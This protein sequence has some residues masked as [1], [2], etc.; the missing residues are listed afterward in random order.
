MFRSFPSFVRRALDVL[1]LAFCKLN[2]I[3]FEAPWRPEE[4]R[5]C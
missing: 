1:D 5:R 3:Q 2:R 4:T